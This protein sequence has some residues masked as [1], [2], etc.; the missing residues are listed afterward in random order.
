MSGICDTVT[1]R[2]SQKWRGRAGVIMVGLVSLDTEMHP[3]QF[4]LLIFL[5]AMT[6]LTLFINIACNKYN[7]KYSSR[8][9]LPWAGHWRQKGGAGFGLYIGEIE[10][11]GRGGLG[12]G[13][14]EI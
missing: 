1:G 14:T 5:L 4:F 2:E 3:G 7:C 12:F 9:L 8:D 10:K 11:W 6:A 13:E